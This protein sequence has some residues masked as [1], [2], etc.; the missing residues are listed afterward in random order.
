MGA[1]I[2]D[3]LGEAAT[4]SGLYRRSRGVC[5]GVGRP[6]RIITS[7]RWKQDGEA[8][9]DADAA[10]ALLTIN[11]SATA[12]SPSTF[13][14]LRPSLEDQLGRTAAQA[15]DALQLGSFAR[16][17]FR[18]DHAERAWITDVASS[19]GISRKSSSCK[20]LAQLGFDHQSTLR[21]VIAATLVAG[22]CSSFAPDLDTG[23]LKAR[24]K[25]SHS[26]RRASPFRPAGI[27]ERGRWHRGPTTI[28]HDL[29][30]QAMPLHEDGAERVRDPSDGVVEPGPLLHGS[31]GVSGE[32]ASHRAVCPDHVH[33]T[34]LGIGAV[35]GQLIPEAIEDVDG[36]AKFA[37]KAEIAPSAFSG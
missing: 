37:G 3:E 1:G 5:A 31:L 28:P 13:I 21:I 19:P 8:P 10:N 14:G 15:F 24:P 4:P 33:D 18:I 36:L 34:R 26:S 17:D 35:A 2:A 16:I 27:V 22:G 23:I 32:E 20:S 6:E 11:S 25:F 7:A 29:G 12:A 30:Q 9:D